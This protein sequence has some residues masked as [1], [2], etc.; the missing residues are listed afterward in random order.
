MTAAV[1]PIYVEFKGNATNLTTTINKAKSDIKAF[2]KQTDETS[3]SVSRS[4]SVMKAAF[5]T[6]SVAAI[7]GGIKS[8]VTA[9]SNLQESM[10][11]VDVVFG[12]NA[13]S[14]QNWA[15]TTSSAFGINRTAAL[16]AAGTY[17]NLM[18]AFGITEQ[19]AY[20]MSTSMVELAA[21]L[22]SFNNTSID[23][24]LLALRSGLSGEMEPLKKFGVALTDV[25]LR[26]QALSMNLIKTTSEVLPPAIKM[27]AAYALI[28]KD[29]SLAQGDMARTAGGF[30]NQMRFLQAGIVDAKTTLGEALLPALTT[31]VT[32]LNEKIIPSIQNFINGLTGKVSLNAAFTD[33]QKKIYAWG[34]VVRSI[35]QTVVNYKKYIIAFGGAIVAMWAIAKVSA[36]A[37][38]IVKIIGGVTKAYQVM[39]AVAGGA[40]IASAMAT[41]GLSLTA[42]AVG[43]AAGTAAVTAAM[44]GINKV[45]GKYN[46]TVQGLPTYGA[47]D[48][49][50][51]GQ[52][53][54]GEDISLPTIGAGTATGIGSKG[55]PKGKKAVAKAKADIKKFVANITAARKAGLNAIAK[56]P[57]LQSAAT[58][59]AD[60]ATKAKGFLASAAAEE[61]SLRKTKAH[62]AAKK[63]LALAQKNYN[64]ALKKSQDLNQ[65]ILDLNKKLADQQAAAAQKAID[66]QNRL[67]RAL[68]RTREAS[69]SWLAASAKASGPT[70]SNFGGFIEVPVVI[71]GQTVFRA[72]QR[73]SLINNRRN[74]S[75][76]LA[77]SGSLI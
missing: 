49:V 13:T 64:E 56:S 25:R 24:A 44:Y 37:S 23:D 62:A 30:A 32:Y 39:R 31:L 21:D 50:M 61:K 27:Q 55:K 48:G 22:A 11:K 15:Q 26:E 18:R 20:K 54:S 17:G 73:Y 74:V 3:A 5:A 60:Y 4:S 65:A 19:S 59:A 34:T 16:E 68:A 76:G 1:P 2:G 8:M 47:P 43:L 58:A 33:S 52:T 7:V 29:T 70:Q 69:R 6:V 72:T 14:V 36:A 66:E 63:A 51:Q 9:A 12:A 77:R 10:T 41:G 38:V 45:M 40:T 53:S 46:E 67:Y 75:N 35:I 42:A 28:M 71:D 57:D